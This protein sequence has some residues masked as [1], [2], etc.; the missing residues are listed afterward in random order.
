[1]AS[2]W[3]H[4]SPYLGAYLNRFIGALRGGWEGTSKDGLAGPRLFGRDV[5]L[6]A[7]RIGYPQSGGWGRKHSLSSLASMRRLP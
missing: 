1:M 6:R 3:S 7:W 4:F 2:L 5:R